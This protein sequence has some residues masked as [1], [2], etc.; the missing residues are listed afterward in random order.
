M[1][2][3]ASRILIVCVMTV[4]ALCLLGCEKNKVDEN[5]RILNQLHDGVEQAEREAERAQREYDQLLKDWAEY[6]RLK[7]ALDNAKKP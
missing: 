2:R 1:P 4:V 7:S 5:Q 6:E 3:R